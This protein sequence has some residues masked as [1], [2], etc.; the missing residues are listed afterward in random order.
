[1]L[2]TLLLAAAVL[3]VRGYSIASIAPLCRATLHPRASPP[4]AAAAELGSLKGIASDFDVFL[5]DQ[6]GVIH[7]GT[8]AYDGAVDAVRY[9][10]SL[11]KKIVIISNSSRRKSDTTKRL[12]S[13]GFGPFGEEAPDGGTTPIS[14]VTSGDLVWQGLLGEGD[15]VAGNPL[16]AGL[17]DSCFCF[18]NGAEDDEYLRSS[19]KRACDVG[20][21]DFLLA[22]GLFSLHGAAGG[23][24]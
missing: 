7:D 24:P 22:R 13:M 14:V 21:A 1:M 20:D 3:G 2:Q 11:G 18:G 12:A 23:W 6:F 16:F 17:G 9:L 5:L 15:G 4:W 8:A 19:G 10:Q